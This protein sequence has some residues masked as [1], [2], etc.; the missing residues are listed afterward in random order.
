MAKSMHAKAMIEFE[1]VRKVYQGY[2]YVAFLTP[3]KYA[4]SVVVVNY[5]ALGAPHL[6]APFPQRPQTPHRLLA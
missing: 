3:A 5:V 6:T 2:E 4:A 1:G